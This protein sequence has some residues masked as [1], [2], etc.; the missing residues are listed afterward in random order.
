MTEHRPHPEHRPPTEHRPPRT[1]AG[2]GVL[3][4]LVLLAV[5]GLVAAVV[6]AGRTADD[7]SG[8]AA[9]ATSG[10]PG[11]GVADGVRLGVLEADPARDGEARAAGITAVTLSLAWDRWEPRPGEVDAA[12]VGAV[13]D[14]VAGLRA[15]GLT[16]ALDLGLQYPPD[17]VLDLPGAERFTDQ[18][19]AVSDRGPGGRLVDAVFVPAVRDAQQRYLDRVAAALPASSLTAV[20]VGGLYRGQLGYPPSVPGRTSLWMYGAA[21]Q[22]GAPVPG[23]RPGTGTPDDARRSLEYYLDSITGY[24]RWLLGTVAARFPDVELDLL[25][26]SWGLRPGQVAAAA[27][28]RLDGSTPG[29]ATDAV[30][31]GLD[32]ERQVP[33]L[34]EVGPRGVA[35]TTW[36]D[37]ADSGPRPAQRA[38][39]ARVAELAAPL[40]VRVGGENTGGTGAG[41]TGGGGPDALRRSL[42]Q[43]GEHGLVALSWRTEADVLDDPVMVGLLRAAAGR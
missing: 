12:Y 29:E 37:A 1:A 5:V 23:W 28:A 43:V 19:G 17:W 14:R 6:V 41:G 34:A 9:S 20:R 40:G 8:P 33:L 39:V 18:D 42:A 22:A 15:A 11:A 38:P 32:W 21:A 4:G 31:E 16:A 7:P 10:A 25:L 3:L 24:G 36:L 27:D 13:A 26:P 2:R 35:W 30:S